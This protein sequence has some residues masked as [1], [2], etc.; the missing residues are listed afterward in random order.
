[1]EIWINENKATV[2]VI[3]IFFKAK[4]SIN[5]FDSNVSLIPCRL[6]YDR[7]VEA[8]RL[9]MRVVGGAPLSTVVRWL[10]AECH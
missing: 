3:L 6:I 10:V 7:R 8:L 2:Q 1:M 4:L 5:I 9:L